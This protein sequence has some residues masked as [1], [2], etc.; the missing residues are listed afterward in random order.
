MNRFEFVSPKTAAEAV[1]LLGGGAVAK[2]GGTDLVARI[3]DRLLEPAKLVNL[4]NVADL[5]KLSAD[6]GGLKCGALVTLS[7]LAA[8]PSARKMYAALANAAGEA[9]TPQIRNVAT[10]GGNLCQR[11]RCW[12]YRSAEHSCVKK[13]GTGCPALD[14]ENQYHAIFDN[15]KCA[16]V[17]ASNLAPALIALE[18]KI[19]IRGKGGE[20]TVGAEEF[21]AVDDVTKETILGENEVVTGIEAAS[22]WKSAYLELRERQSFDWPLVAVAVAVKGAGKV[23]AARIVLGA[24]SPAPMRAAKAEKAL[25]GAG[26]KDEAAIAKV[27]A[28]AVEGAKPLGRNGYKVTML[29]AMVARAIAAVV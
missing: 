21:Y 23:E 17:E 1:G 2:A 7:E 8:H 20:K 26:L 24:V 3:K 11:P 16:A 27:A 5:K 25:V 28:A 22:G 6:D 15:G 19:T 4:L 18:G 12:Y 29:K 9:A 13:G 14:G 10:V